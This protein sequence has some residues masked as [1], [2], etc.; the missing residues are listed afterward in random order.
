M[1][2]LIIIIAYVPTD[3]CIFWNID[4]GNISLYHYTMV[5]WSLLKILVKEGVVGTEYKLG[6]SHTKMFWKNRRKKG[7]KSAQCNYVKI[8]LK[9]DK[10]KYLH[11][12]VRK[13]NKTDGNTG[14]VTYE[15]CSN[16]IRKLLV[17]FSHQ[18]TN[19]HY[20]FILF[21]SLMHF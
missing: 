10:L 21:G 13:L 6:A 9:I 8:W 19:N 4:W 20:W 2:Y 12:L 11:Q 18:L 5:W 14:D 1:I 16:L 7:A 17:Y 3:T 15:V